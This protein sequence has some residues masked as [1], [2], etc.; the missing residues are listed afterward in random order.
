MLAT[1]VGALPFASPILSASGTFGAGYEGRSFSDLGRVGAIVTKTVTMRPRH[2]NAT[3]RIIETPCGMLNSIGLEN[4]GVDEFLRSS[5]P[6]SLALGRPVVVNIGGETVEEYEELARRFDGS[7]AVALELNLSCPNVQGGR[8]PFATD[9]KVTESVVA[10]AR[11]ATRLPIWA[12]LSPNVT[13]IGDLARAAEAGGADAIVAIN[14]LIGMAVDWQNRRPVLAETIGG[15][16]GPAIKAVALRMVWEVVKAVR[17]PVVGVGGIA[18]ADD[19][20]E[21][22]VVG[23][24]AVEIGTMNYVDP[25]RMPALVFEVE[26]KLAAAGTSVRELIGTLQVRPVHDDAG[27]RLP[28]VAAAAGTGGPR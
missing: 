8:L 28:G 15:L 18:T 3:P 12:K 1:Q 19:V 6:K 22:L 21:F 16:S 17:I 4:R 5:L 14:T 23:A 9:P 20:L 2:G 24:S 27:A 11:A 13:R 10:R 26:A 7:G 25:A